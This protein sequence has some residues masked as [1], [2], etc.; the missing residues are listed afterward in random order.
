M[1][2]ALVAVG[3]VL[4]VPA[5]KEPQE[6]GAPPSITRADFRV[7]ARPSSNRQHQENNPPLF[8]LPG[9]RHCLPVEG[10]QDI[11]MIHLASPI[12]VAAFRFC[13]SSEC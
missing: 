5:G 9:G 8:S 11:Q 13:R 6:I 7:P 10:V 1:L 2:H 3:P 12:E 4:Q